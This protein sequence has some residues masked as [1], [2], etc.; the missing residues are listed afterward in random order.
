MD[1]VEES[2]KHSICKNGFPVKAVKLPFRPIYECCKQN[3]TAL[4][5]VLG[6]LAKE[7]IFGKIKGDFIEFRSA[8]NPEKKEGQSPPDLGRLQ[9]LLKVFSAGQSGADANLEGLQKTALEQMAKMTP[10]Q[11]A[12]LRGPLDGLSDE[13]KQNILKNLAR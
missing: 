7:D 13:D 3:S 9:E 11:I 2:I 4:A 10:G 8:S 5:D 1:R 6:N 12:E